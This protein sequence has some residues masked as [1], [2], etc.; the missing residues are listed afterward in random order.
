MTET[1]L[2]YRGKKDE[3]E[4]ILN[5]KLIKAY[6]KKLITIIKNKLPYKLKTT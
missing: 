3:T 4:I 5:Q 2:E 6:H 1:D